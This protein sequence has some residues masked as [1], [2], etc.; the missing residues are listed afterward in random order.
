MIRNYYD[1]IERVKEQGFLPFF[2]GEIPGFSLA[3]ITPP[4]LWFP[5]DSESLGVWEW[6]GPVILDGDCAYGKFY[7]N[8]A[9]FIS[10]ECFPHFANYRRSTLPLSPT[11][12]LILDAIAHSESLLSKEVKRLCGYTGRD[13]AARPREGF[14]TAIT[15]LQMSCRLVTADFEYSFD[16]FGKRYGWGVAR[17][18]TPEAFFGPERMAVDC[19]PEES[20]QW[21][22]QYLTAKLPQATERQI[23]RI[24]G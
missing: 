21:L 8:K 12:Q 16:R 17:Y 5:D 2:R 6:K 4:A 22:Q 18:C 9:C 7:L 10:M 23:N 1:I 14:D 11:E 15:R 19:S 3:E 13:K 24:I 20:R